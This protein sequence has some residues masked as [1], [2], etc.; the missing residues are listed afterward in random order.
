MRIYAEISVFALIAIGVHAAGFAVAPDNGDQSSGDAGEFLV[1]LQGSTAQME[2][3][4][5]DWTAPPDIEIVIPSLAETVP[6]LDQAEM[7]PS[8]LGLLPNPNTSVVLPTQ[9]TVSS[10]ASEIAIPEAATEPAEKPKVEIAPQAVPKKKPKPRPKKVE[11]GKEAK[12]KETAKAPKKIAAKKKLATKK[13][14]SQPA[15]E[16]QQKQKAAGQGGQSS[17]GSSGK[18]KVKSGSSAKTAKALDV[19]GAQIRRS[20]ERRKKSVRGLKR[21][22]RVTMSVTVS[23]NGQILSFRIA[24]SSGN[25][26]AD[27]AALRAVNS[28]GQV[29]KAAK[30]VAVRKHTFRVPMIFNP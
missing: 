8:S 10:E 5:A 6:M 15:Q 14:K 3:L 27:N 22:A 18:A 24:K 4:V 20:I 16:G 30:G 7:P 28:V 19:W 26:K 17:A 23:A 1:S 29:P 21:R 12:P 11:Q 13:K 2:Q 25:K 9:P